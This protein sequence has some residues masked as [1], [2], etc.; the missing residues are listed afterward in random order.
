MID[1]GSAL[2]IILPR[3][4]KTNIKCNELRD[5]IRLNG[6]GDGSAEVKYWVKLSLPYGIK[7]V[8]FVTYGDFKMKEDAILGGDFLETNK[9]RLDYKE[10]VI[11]VGGN[12]I[13]MFSR[14]E[15]D[16]SLEVESNE[17]AK[18]E[19]S[20]D[21]ACSHLASDVGDSSAIQCEEEAF[22]DTL[23]EICSSSE[24]EDSSEESSEE[25]EEEKGTEIDVEFQSRPITKM[26]SVPKRASVY[27]KVNV[28]KNGCGFIKEIKFNDE[29]FTMCSLVVAKNNEATVAFVNLS[30]EDVELLVPQVELTQCRDEEIL[31]NEIQ[32][33]RM[34]ILRTDKRFERLN[35]KVDLK[36]LNQ[37]E[38]KSIT[39]L[40]EEFSDVFYLDGDVLSKNK[41]LEHEIEVKENVKP[42]NLRQYKIPFALR[43][44]MQKQI[45]KMVES[46]LIE[47]STS[48]WN[49]PVMLVPKKLDNSLEKKFRLVI[50]LR[51]L[52]ELV[53]QDSYPLPIIDEIL[54][55]LG[56]AMYFSTLDLY[57]G[58]YQIGLKKNSRSFTSFSANGRKWQFKRLPMGLKNAPAYFQ[59]MMTIILSNLLGVNCFL[60][61]DDIIIIGSSLEDHNK[62]LRIVFERLRSA[63]LKLAPAKCDI[64]RKECLFLGHRI[65]QEGIFPDESKFEAIKSFKIPKSR[66]QVR[67]FLGLTGYYR[68]FIK[69]YGKI[70][71]PLN[72]LTSINVD[73]KW[74]DRHTIAFDKL[75]E[76]LI[77]PPILIY[78]NFD[79]EFILT[80]D[81]S[82][83]GIGAVLS[84]IRNNRDMPIAFASKALSSREQITMRDSAIEKELLAIVWATK[85]FKQYLYG[86]KFTVFTDHR[87]LTY[88]NSMCNTNMKLMKYKADLSEFD[89]DIKYKKGCANTNADALS[90]MF[91]IECLDEDERRLLVNENHASPLAG[92]RSAETT[93]QRI[94]DAG[95]S[96]PSINKDVALF[97]KTCASCQKNKLYR[98]TKMPMQITDTPTKPWEKV[99]LDIVGKL[100]RTIMGHEYILTIQDIFSKF[101]FAIPLSNQDAEA[102]AQAFFTIIGMHGIPQE[103]LTDRGTNFLS[104]LFKSLCKLFKIKKIATSA[105][106]PQSN[107]SIERMHRT[108]KEYVRHFVNEEQS[109]WDELLNLAC[110]AHN[111]CVHSS[112]NYTPFELFYG[113]KVNVPSSLTKADEHGKFYS[114]DEYVDRLKHNMRQSFAI[115]RK[116]LELSKEKNKRSFDKSL[117]PKE[118]RIGEQVQLLIEAVRQGRSKKLGP[119]WSGPYVVLEK[120]GD[121]N[122]KIKMGRTTKIVHA[123]KLKNYYE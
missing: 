24:N 41:S 99:S 108:L 80:T 73:F 103:I 63:G 9:A 104:K 35:E 102:V 39:S 58:F 56:N 77:N 107:G 85:Y 118:F 27:S 53:V 69:D 87:P 6:I 111:T 48:P 42:L 119:Q 46:D 96:W 23:T 74:E 17:I 79:E 26:I 116:N 19:T 98:T 2:S 5:A 97:I 83:T 109:N 92:H 13:A 82:G 55:Q 57:S 90:R 68:K 21:M 115:A 8:F 3:A 101:I 93:I 66:K 105:Y 34:F 94:K 44:E 122:Y 121:V 76:L 37:Q 36:H 43:G 1:S 12:K 64:L 30:N 106:R 18:V 84:Q 28:N 81:A 47:E 113:R 72:K 67:S 60:Y 25:E 40:L 31:S 100:P 33:V 52:N 29:V 20:A 16:I 49:M 54:G 59:R 123:N 70:A 15:L 89:F 91:M 65:T 62:N 50:D 51:K 45:E 112:T 78:P 120:F 75:K 61:M 32:E 38:K 117:N 11:K 86:R 88:L 22:D 7:Q 10:N 14:V 114:Y 71:A 4:L 110:F 95:F